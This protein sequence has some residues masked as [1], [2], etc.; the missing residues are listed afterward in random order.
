MCWRW[1]QS[2]PLC[3][4][5][6]HHEETPL[7]GLSLCQALTFLSSSVFS[8]EI[9]TRPVSSPCPGLCPHYLNGFCLSCVCLGEGTVLCII[10]HVTNSTDILVDTSSIY[11]P[12][13]SCLRYTGSPWSHFAYRNK[14]EH[15]AAWAACWGTDNRLALIWN[16]SPLSRHTKPKC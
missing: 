15:P 12:S 3:P 11:T 6:F 5:T 1:F 9:L 8:V 10:C 2:K 4:H 16:C 13:H 14:H 7:C